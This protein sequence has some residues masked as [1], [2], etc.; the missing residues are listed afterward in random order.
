[1]CLSTIY[2]EKKDNKNKIMENVCS[3]ELLT[4]GIKFTDLMEKTTLYKGKLIKAD[5]V[6]GYVIVSKEE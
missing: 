2:V 1:M 3:I 5:L 6:D 4:E